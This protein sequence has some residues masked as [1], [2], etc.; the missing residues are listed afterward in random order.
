MLSAIALLTV[1]MHQS[2]AVPTPPITGTW[3]SDAG[4]LTLALKNNVLTVAKGSQSP[5]TF[6]VDG[7]GTVQ[8][9]KTV[10]G[11]EWRHLSIARWVGNA[12]LITNL[13]TRESGAKWQWMSVYSLDAASGNLNV[14]TVDNGH[15]G[16]D[17]MVTKLEVYRKSGG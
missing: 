2:Q 1:L 5:M 13:T 10:A 3:I 15:E 12:V 4:R 7:T 11:E 8:V 14:V 16:G 6:K 17:G 9:T